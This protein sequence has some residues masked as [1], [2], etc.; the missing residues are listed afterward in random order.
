MTHCSPNGELPE[1]RSQHCSALYNG[2]LYIYGG[3]Y[4]AKGSWGYCESY[5]DDLWCIDI[6]KYLKSCLS[7]S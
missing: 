5:L 6:G 3:Y 7:L 1:A 4:T 2:K